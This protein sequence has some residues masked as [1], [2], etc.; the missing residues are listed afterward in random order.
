MEAIRAQHAARARVDK[1][2]VALTFFAGLIWLIAFAVVRPIAWLWI[3]AGWVKAAAIVGARD[4]W[5]PV[6]AAQR[7]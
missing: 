4:G 7:R 2:A 3:A 1:K 5:A 6:R